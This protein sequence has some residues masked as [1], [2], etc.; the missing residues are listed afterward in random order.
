[1]LFVDFTLKL[2]STP[3]RTF[4]EVFVWKTFTWPRY[5]CEVRCRV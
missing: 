2:E 3:Q 5:L 4:R 1:M